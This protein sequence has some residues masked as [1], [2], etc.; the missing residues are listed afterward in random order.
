MTMCVEMIF[1]GLLGLL[2]FDLLRFVCVVGFFSAPNL[3]KNTTDL[4]KSICFWKI[5]EVEI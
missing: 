2:D 1:M 4:S 3:N 5:G